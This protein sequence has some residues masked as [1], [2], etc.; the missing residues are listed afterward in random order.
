MISGIRNKPQHPPRQLTLHRQTQLTPHHQ[1]QLSLQM[2]SWG[3]N[4]DGQLG[5]GGVDAQPV[6]R[7]VLC[8]ALAKVRVVGVGAANRHSAAVTSAGDTFTWG[9]NTYGQLGYTTNEAS[10][11][12]LPR[13][14]GRYLLTYHISHKNIIFV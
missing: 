7:K 13:K 5:Y 4:R 3:L 8:P 2:Y 12:Q 11:N 6:P 14:V 1:P 9:D 10:A